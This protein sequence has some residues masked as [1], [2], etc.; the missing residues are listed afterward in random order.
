MRTTAYLW[1]VQAS[2]EETGVQR[3]AL[4]VTGTAGSGTA[5]QDAPPA[6][7]DTGKPGEGN[8][9]VS[10]KTGEPVRTPWISRTLA[11]E[12]RETGCGSR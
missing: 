4:P 9:T 5:D 7:G 3:S 2:P 12:N 6:G 11:A 1:Y 8:D 10:P